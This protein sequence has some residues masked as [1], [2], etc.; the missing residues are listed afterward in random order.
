MTKR[1]PTTK[2]IQYR[3]HMSSCT[4]LT[5]E[6]GLMCVLTVYIACV[7]GNSS[8]MVVLYVPSTESHRLRIA[9]WAVLE[10]P[11]GRGIPPTAVVDPHA[12]HDV[13]GLPIAFFLVRPLVVRRWMMVVVCELSKWFESRKALL[14][15]SSSA[16]SHSSSNVNK[17]GEQHPRCRARSITALMHWR[18]DASVKPRHAL[19]SDD[20]RQTSDVRRWRN[21]RAAERRCSVRG[22][23]TVIISSSYLRLLSKL[24]YATFTCIS[25]RYIAICTRP[26]SI[27]LTRCHSSKA[28]YLCVCCLNVTSTCIFIQHSFV[29]AL[30]IASRWTCRVSEKSSPMTTPSIFR[31]RQRP[32]PGRGAGSAACRRLLL[33][34]VITTSHDLSQFKL[35]VIPLGQVLFI[36]ELSMT[37][38]FIGG[39]Y[40][41]ICVIG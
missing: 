18:S 37:T 30:D 6:L 27:N 20:V 28:S 23:E 12:I 11:G 7:S 3:V 31:L 29:C 16:A 15:S 25:Q 8:L 40:N 17:S 32:I 41:Q 14:N 1:R 38:G 39:W 35:E 4:K 24:S 26:I 36:D 2:E 5:S 10:L 34:S 9:L 13:E 33:L 19:T 22:S 21:K